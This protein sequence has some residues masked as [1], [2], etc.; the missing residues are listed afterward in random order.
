MSNNEM[1]VGNVTITALSD[2]IFRALARETYPEVPERV[3]TCGCETPES[4]PQLENNI[5][6]YLVRSKGRTIMVDT[7]AGPLPPDP[8]GSVWGLLMDDM[9][10]QSID[11]D[12]I[13]TV[14]MTHLHFDHVG[15]NLRKENGRYL[16]VFPKAR[17]IAS[18]I[19][20]NFFRNEPEAEERYY[21]RPEP[22]EPL[23]SLGLIDLI[24]DEHHLTDELTA[25]HTPGHTPGHMSILISS[26]GEKGII[27]GDV[28]HNPLQVHE[29][30]WKVDAD[31]DHD[32]ARMTRESIMKRIEDE[33]LK[34]AAG[35]FPAPGFG[36]VI[37][38]EG[39]RYWKAL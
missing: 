32:Q 6:S 27:L 15:W 22:V 26:Q 37:R 2:G 16:P 10:A 14:F 4:P 19:D 31:V 12:Q 7:G 5:G 20:W 23:E 35:H 33:G 25:I 13:D 36:K 34:M 28:A 17:Y 21:Y 30:G 29:T 24:D 8:S 11:V 3:W 38:L 39:K 1:T 9:K 18:S